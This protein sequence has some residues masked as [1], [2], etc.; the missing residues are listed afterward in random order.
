MPVSEPSGCASAIRLEFVGGEGHR[1]VAPG[2]RRPLG[3]DAVGA[4]DQIGGRS[5]G[6][7]DDVEP[8]RQPAA[9]EVG[10]GE[11]V[12]A[13]SRPCRHARV[14][15]GAAAGRRR[16]RAA[17]AARGRR[18][19]LSRISSC[20]PFHAAQPA[21]SKKN[22]AARGAAGFSEVGT[23]GESRSIPAGGRPRGSLP[24]VTQASIGSRRAQKASSG[25]P[26]SAGPRRDFVHVRRRNPRR[27]SSSSDMSASSAMRSLLI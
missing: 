23:T 26:P 11:A 18:S 6:F 14:P 12:E 7:G 22:P 2:D 16:A 4:V 24:A 27:Q 21:K 20:R 19:R 15:P 3:A 9:G 25:M 13:R 1:Q 5:V 17:P 8:E 10:E